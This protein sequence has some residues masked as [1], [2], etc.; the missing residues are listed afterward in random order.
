MN[1]FLN[2]GITRKTYI[3]FFFLGLALTPILFIVSMYAALSLKNIVADEQ[4]L[5]VVPLAAL[6]IVGIYFYVLKVKRL[7][8]LDRTDRE[9]YE[10]NHV[11]LGDFALAYILLFKESGEA[12]HVVQKETTVRVIIQ[13]VILYLVFF[14]INYF[15]ILVLA[16]LRN[17]YAPTFADIIRKPFSYFTLIYLLVYFIL[18]FIN[19]SYFWRYIKSWSR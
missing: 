14:F 3:K 18:P 10:A 16:E 9:I 5:T 12:K 7:K 6:V 8:D 2:K 17:F 4:Y 19:A 15:L 1:N 11:P 13:R